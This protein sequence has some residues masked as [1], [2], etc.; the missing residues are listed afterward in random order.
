[1]AGRKFY[2][3]AF[4]LAACC[5]FV[6]AQKKN[7]RPKPDAPNT[8]GRLAANLTHFYEF[9]RP[10]FPI[11]RVVIRHDDKGVGDITFSLSDIDEP[12]TDPIA[13][14]AST[15]GRIYAALDELDFLNSTRNYQ[16]EKD[17]PH[18]GNIRFT[19]DR[20]GKKRT[21]T[22]NWTEVS[23]AR[24]LM[25]EYRRIGN[26]FVWLFK[27]ELARKNLP[28]EAPKLVDQ[29]GGYLRREEISDPVQMIP[30]LT[31]LAED[32][33]VPLIARNGSLKLIKEIEKA[34]EK[35]LR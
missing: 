22:Y 8:A 34:S 21:V 19:L 4:L 30:Y 26:Q 2:A 17:Y 24:A 6:N 16:F 28:L 32:E 35:A 25:D 15:L 7:D 14:S 13:L 29:L 3:I 9:D 31:K 27:I 18:L 23:G 5:A 11:S 1:M 33:N 12:I 10:N 20:E